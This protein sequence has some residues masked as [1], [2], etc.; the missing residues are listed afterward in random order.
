MDDRN[1]KQMDFQ[2]SVPHSGDPEQKPPS[3]LMQEGALTQIAHLRN[4]LLSRMLGINTAFQFSLPVIKIL[5]SGEK[6]SK[7]FLLKILDT[8][9]QF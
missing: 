6:Q 4:K 1:G 2:P 3:S 9:K 5:E 8:S 7:H